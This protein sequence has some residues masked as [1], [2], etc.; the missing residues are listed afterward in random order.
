M[1]LRNL[2]STFFR[3]AFL[4]HATDTRRLFWRSD[5]IGV[6]S[7]C[8]RGLINSRSCCSGRLV[9]CWRRT[10]S[11]SLVVWRPTFFSRLEIVIR[12]IAIGW[13]KFNHLYSFNRY[14]C[15]FWAL[16]PVL[17]SGITSSLP[18]L[19]FSMILSPVSIHSSVATTLNKLCNCFSILPQ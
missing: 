1:K 10:Y 17:I 4:G 19:I 18:S 16:S 11:F 12:F 6:C 9:G 13:A 2:G 14:F 7:S 3:L 15:H 8:A 5:V